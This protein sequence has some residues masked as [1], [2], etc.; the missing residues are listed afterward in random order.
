MCAS[1]AAEEPQ[2]GRSAGWQRGSSSHVT[3]ADKELH[4]LQAQ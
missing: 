2:V 4:L 3:G 1:G